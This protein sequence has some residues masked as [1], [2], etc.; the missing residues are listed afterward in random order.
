MQEKIEIRPALS[1]DL[2]EAPDLPSWRLHHK[3][4]QYLALHFNPFEFN[5][6]LSQEI[7][8]IIEYYQLERLLHDPYLFSNQLLIWL[9]QTEHALKND[10]DL[11]P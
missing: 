2:L 5:P 3:R 7:T 11:H 9:D 10:H 1:L 6:A 8:Q 4:L